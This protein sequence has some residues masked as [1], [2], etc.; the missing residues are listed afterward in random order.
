MRT[1]SIRFRLA[2]WYA[3][4]LACAL[5]L[6]GG[7]VWWSLRARL[8]GEIDRELEGR[9]SRFEQYFRTESA[10]DPGP[11]LR[12]ELEEFCQALPPGSFISISGANGFSFAYPMTARIA[13]LRTTRR[14]FRLNGEPFVLEAGEPVGEVQHTLDLLR[15]LL[16]SL[17]PGVILIACAGGA[18]LSHRALKPVMEATEAAHLIS[19][20]NL[21]AR[22]PVPD[23]GDEIA[24]LNE[25]LNAMLGRLESAV[26]TLSHFVADASHELRTPL[27]VIRTTA[28]LALRRARSPEA[29]R[30]SLQE[31]AAETERMTQLVED[32]LLLARTDTGT[33][34]MPLAQL[35]VRDVVRD[36][37]A[38]MRA[39]AQV[40]GIRVTASFGDAAATVAGN[41]AGLHRLFLVLVDNALKFSR[42]GGEV[43][44][45]VA[46]DDAR[47][48]VTVE[49]FGAGIA[50]AELPKIFRRFY[51]SD[52][53]G[54]GLGLALAESI[55]R[56]HRAEI[57]VRS[58][59]GVGSKFTVYFAVPASK[60][61]E[62][63][64]RPL[65]PRPL[66]NT[67]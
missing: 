57:E 55:A 40:L 28:E 42:E 49:D 48:S 16:A 7:L 26:T 24:R 37:C 13:G 31:I 12:D 46:R 14:E 54:H 25:V 10:E 66:S 50:D 19:I 20:E 1:R 51:R 36:V 43:V 64:V 63:G 62:K 22:L 60:G 45:T 52:G 4:V 34:E 65:Y 47:V 11:Q 6:F 18:W 5:S 17:I 38:E 3:A 15:L 29:Y 56:A 32:L 30:E 33:V 53:G 35:D 41:R 39:L 8:T 23:S 2:A 9:A 21:S 27:A 58:E 44:V 61:A 59:C 67:R